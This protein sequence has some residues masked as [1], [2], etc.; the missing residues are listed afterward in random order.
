MA[1]TPRGAILQRDKKTYAIV[2]RSPAGLLTAE[3]LEAFARVVRKYE[4][5]IIK[6]TSGQRLAFVGIKGEDVEKVWSDLGM[7]PGKATELCVH[8]AQA[9]PG[10]AVCRF[11]VQDS[12]GLGLELEKFF[13][14]VE[15]PAKLKF[16]VSGCPFCC[17][18]SYVR[19]LG[20]IGK[21]S[22][23]TVVVGGHSG[24]RPR[25]ADEIAEDL[26]TEQVLDLC[27]KSLDHYRANAKKKE[28]MSAFVERIGLESFKQSVL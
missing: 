18:E 28:R 9:C 26:T 7:D 8:Y 24:G 11:G 15:L 6:V 27:K 20:V 14:G 4:I 22:G 25:I 13:E 12:L 19:D 5:P 23:W 21:K 10:T 3:N 2:P 17:A 1:E 16:G